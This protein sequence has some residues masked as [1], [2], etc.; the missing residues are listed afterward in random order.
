L[1]LRRILF[2]ALLAASL[3]ASIVAQS[4]PEPGK[5]LLVL[6]FQDNSAVQ[7]LD[8]ISESFPEVLSP[9][10]TGFFVIGRQERRN[11]FERMGL[12]ANLR[13]SRAT[14]YQIAQAM[15]VDYVVL[16]SY[17]YDGHSFSASAQVLDMQRLHLSSAA[18]ASGS[19][20]ALIQV[21]NLLALDLLHQLSPAL[22]TSRNEFLSAQPGPRPDAFENYMRGLVA[23]ARQDKIA[24]FREAVRLDPTYTQA[25]FELGKSLYEGRDYAAAA[26]WLE[27][28][29]ASD[30]L[31]PEASFYRGICDFYLGQFEKAQKAF[32]F[33]AARLPLP[34]VY[35]N[36]GVV[37]GR[38][39]QKSAAGYFERAITADPRDPD[40]R[41]NLA[42]ALARKGDSAGASRQLQELLTLRSSDGE[43][44][45]MLD[46][47]G[48]PPLTPAAAGNAL[49]IKPA[50]VKLPLE[51]IKRNYD[52]ASFRQLAFEI[53]NLSEK[54]LAY[55][56]PHD[57]ALFHVER[58][59]DLLNQ[60]FMGEAE[61]QFREAI[62]LDPTNA[63]AHLGMARVLAEDKPSEARA[64]VRSA[65]ILQPS[66]DAWLVLAQLDLLENKPE[67]ASQEVERALELEPANAAAATLKRDIATRLADKSHAPASQ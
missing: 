1:L 17:A 9:R 55:S 40:Y 18:S 39:G 54:K 27:H 29:P 46:A 57:H 66:A 31:A 2:I 49:A 56:A 35:N 26:S 15:E 12:P 8:W 62:V 61:K 47:L 43:A 52:E 51:R 58:G 23:V 3:S 67:Q 10:F 53:E 64:E 13:P 45:A 28:I 24:R 6:P 22:V 36:L 20:S 7:G 4:G 30:A 34:E 5:T 33:V 11:A 25:I 48:A 44:K 21:E 16:G 38:S 50:E 41:F 63:A 37:A 14:A 32:D 19:L 60:G 59:R 65:L 42:I